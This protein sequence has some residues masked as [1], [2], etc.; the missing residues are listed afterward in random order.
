MNLFVL[1]SWQKAKNPGEYI[2]IHELHD[3]SDLEPNTFGVLITDINDKTLQT[4]IS[5][6]FGI[7]YLAK[8]SED[9]AKGRG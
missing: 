5:D 4:E 3:L 7:D 6:V 9:D 1:Q 2:D 8:A